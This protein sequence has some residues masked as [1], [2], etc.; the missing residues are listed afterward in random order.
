MR[1]LVREYLAASGAEWPR[2]VGCWASDLGDR[3]ARVGSVKG[4]R[5][6]I[7]VLVAKVFGEP[8]METRIFAC[9]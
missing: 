4:R 6:K 3:G 8:E 1:I 9:P 7:R 2:S 5:E